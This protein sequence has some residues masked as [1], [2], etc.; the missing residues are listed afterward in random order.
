VIFP[1]G[2]EQTKEELLAG[3]R[4]EFVESSIIPRAA[5]LTSK[6]I[7]RTLKMMDWPVELVKL[8]AVI[9][10]VLLMVGGGIKIG[11]GKFTRRWFFPL[12]GFVAYVLLL[13]FTIIDGQ[14]RSTVVSF[15]VLLIGGGASVGAAR[16]II[17]R[18]EAQ[19]VSHYKLLGLLGQGGMGR[20][21]KAMDI[22]TKQTVALKVLNPEIVKNTENKKRLLSEGQLLNS[23]SHPHI[24]HVLE[25]ADTSTG[26]FIAMEFLAGGTL[27]QTLERLHPL[28]LAEIK[29]VLL[30]VCNGL[31]EVH[32][33]GIVHRDLKTGNI[34]FDFSG[35]IRIMDFGLSKSPLV[36]TMTSLG[37]VLGTLGYVAPEQITNQS[38]DQR[39]DIFS[40][41]V[42]ITELL[43]NTLPFKGE[44]EIALIHSIFNI[45]PPPPSTL[46]PDVTSAWDSIVA[47]CLAKN[48]HE[49]YSSAE[50]VRKAIEET[51]TSLT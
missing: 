2:I 3:S 30:Q 11:A 42:I 17:R 44:N 43:T 21:F 16:V 36:T 33:H 4:L 31:S 34:M 20:V 40:L 24:V 29:R 15:G 47:R 26:G 14:F 7:G 35:T 41:G 39:T 1:S 37:T 18:H 5:I 6:S 19:F 50:E 46:R 32:R 28:P 23:F 51:G 22:N 48:P 38:V 13:H 45:V 12:T 49:R 8:A 25:V 27:K 9:V 10:L